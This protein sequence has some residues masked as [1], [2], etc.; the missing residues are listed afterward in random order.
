MMMA[1]TNRR[2]RRK[3]HA[4]LALVLVLAAMLAGCF[5]QSVPATTMSIPN[6]TTTA[7][8]VPTPAVTL[9]ETVEIPDINGYYTSPEDVAAYLNAYQ[10]LPLNYI[11]K[12]EAAK[13]GWDASR[14]NLWDVTDRMSI[15]GDRFGNREGLLP[16][17]DGRIW[18]ECDVNYD[19]G[20]R[21]AERLVYSSDGLIYYTDDH[22]QSFQR[23]Y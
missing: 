18:Y 17:V 10:Q 6:T 22:Y 23:L 1:K 13:L 7:E 3:T 4:L 19:G 12:S 20:Y 8:N 21:G 2:Y 11:S 16:D 9:E 5:A 15:G 14:G